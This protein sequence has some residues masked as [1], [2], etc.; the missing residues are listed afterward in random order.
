MK[1]QESYSYLFLINP[2]AGNGRGLK[3]I[4][5]IKNYLLK[6]KIN[7]HIEISQS[8]GHII[9]LVRSLAN[10]FTH[11]ISVGG[12]GTLNELINGI[13]PQLP[14]M[15]GLLP[16][17]TGNDF[18]R[19]L[20]LSKN[21]DRNLDLI[22]NSTK[23]SIVDIGQTKIIEESSEIEKTYR[24][25][26]S[27]GIGFDALVA[28]LNQRSKHLTGLFSYIY[29]VILALIKHKDI[30]VEIEVGSEKISGKKLLVAIGNGFTTGGGFYLTPNA[31]I[32]DNQLD[33]CIV[34]SVK[35]LKILRSLPKALFNKLDKVKE[36]KLLNFSQT[37]IKLKEPTIVHTD[38]EIVT[39]IGK[40]L[41]ISI[42]NS[43]LK[44]IST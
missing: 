35:R 38:G 19:N 15:I 39:E 13:N 33:M 24:F 4:D 18:A 20:N 23:H 17:G 1:N 11:L 44:I 9:E 7:H 14:N 21:L 37:K 3:V 12:D 32:N 16:I 40:S 22:F 31:K 34:E 43:K 8:P 41:E 28:K 29:A 42:L 2:V 27:L 10:N 25:I 5:K 26:N 36:A 30:D 6:K